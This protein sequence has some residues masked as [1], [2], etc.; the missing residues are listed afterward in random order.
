MNDDTLGRIATAMERIAGALEG[1]TKKGGGG[2]SGSSTGSSSGGGGYNESPTTKD[3]AAIGS[4][5]DLDTQWGDP[6]IKFVPRG[7]DGPDFKGS[8]M[9]QTSAAFLRWLANELGQGIQKKLRAG[10]E[11]KAGWDRKTQLRAIGW[12]ERLEDRAK[13]AGTAAL[14]FGD[15]DEGDIPF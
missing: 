14:D 1:L 15:S 10:D 9:S 3:G 12:L 8:R 11:E 2:S 13:G 5:A 6:E 7:W 4:P